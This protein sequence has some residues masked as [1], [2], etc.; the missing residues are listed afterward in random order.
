MRREEIEKA[1][2]LEAQAKAIRRAEQQF[3]KDI[4]LRKD[5][6][7]EHFNVGQKDVRLSEKLTLISSEKYGISEIELLEYIMSESVIAYYPKW[8]K[9]QAL[10]ERS[11]G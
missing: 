6:I 9:R 10:G 7:M 5:E 3:W 1:K 4:N 8:K 2:R 11:E